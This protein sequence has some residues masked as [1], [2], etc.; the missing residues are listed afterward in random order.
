MVKLSD[1]QISILKM[2]LFRYQM[3]S[4]L[5]V[6]FASK[7]WNRADIIEL[8]DS[9]K[10]SKFFKYEINENPIVLNKVS[11]TKETIDKFLF[12]DWV[13]FISITGSVAAGDPDE[14]DD[15]D[16][17]IVVKDHRAW[18]Y[19]LVR[20]ILQFKNN[21]LRRYG[22]ESVRDAFCPNFICET[23]SLHFEAEN[24]FTLHEML[25]MIAVYNE[26]FRDSIFRANS[27]IKQYHINV[28][29]FNNSEAEERAVE[30][31]Y[32]WKTINF[33]A[34]LIQVAY[35]VIA[36][37]KPDFKRLL[38]GYKRG[39]I[40][41]YPRDFSNKKL[42]DVE[43]LFEKFLPASASTSAETATTETTASKAA[44]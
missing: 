27:W 32:L 41:F 13:K 21:Q 29:R 2:A 19:R 15:I 22:E 8:A 23:R 18:I 43:L 34:F 10:Y 30:N 17:F 4:V 11:K 6:G 31:L 12:R 39:E 9:Q 14:N 44:A 40:H 3:A 42:E 26:P 16:L 28:D 1:S 36:Q 7:Y 38:N 37:H 5:D 24:I 33:I 25:R 20:L 35:M